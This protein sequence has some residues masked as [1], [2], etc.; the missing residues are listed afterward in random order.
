M[1]LLNFPRFV[2]KTSFY[3]RRAGKPKTAIESERC[4]TPV[5]HAT[6]KWHTHSC[7]CGSLWRLPNTFAGF[8]AYV[9]W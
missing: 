4:R 5:P 2:P 1:I 7:S 3:S 9:P 6:Q 8:R